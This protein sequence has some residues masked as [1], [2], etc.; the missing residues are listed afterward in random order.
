V[1]ARRIIP[2][3]QKVLLLKSKFHDI[4]IQW[5]PREKNKE[6]DMLTNN[7]YNRALQ[8][9]PECLDRAIKKKKQATFG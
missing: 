1:K 4:Q 9:N 2:L 5:V 6:A 8:E 7:A 3:Y